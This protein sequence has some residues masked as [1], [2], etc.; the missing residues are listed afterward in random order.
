MAPARG[1]LPSLAPPLFKM[2]AAAILS[3]IIMACIWL[4]TVIVA[5]A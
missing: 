2:I 1:A 4:I 3:L 5:N